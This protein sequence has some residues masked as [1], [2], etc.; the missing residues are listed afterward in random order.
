MKPKRIDGKECY[1]LDFLSIARTKMS[2]ER[3]FLAYTN[4]SL[5]FLA[6]GVAFIRFASDVRIETV[7]YLLFL[8]S[9]VILVSGFVRFHQVRVLIKTQTCV[10]QDPIC[11]RKNHKQAGTCASETM[12]E[13]D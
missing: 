4:T 3:T 5:A 2:N 9:V 6:T 13:G 11:S 12:A 10:L 7:G 1:T 8:C